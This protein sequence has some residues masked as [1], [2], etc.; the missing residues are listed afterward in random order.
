MLQNNL[1]LEDKS[2]A[3]CNEKKRVILTLLLKEVNEINAEIFDHFS[4]EHKSYK[5]YVS[6]KNKEEGEIEFTPKFLIRLKLLICHLM[7]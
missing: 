6:V 4:A 5:N 1:R 3:Q 2:N 7:S